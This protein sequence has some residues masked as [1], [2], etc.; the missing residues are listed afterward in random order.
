MLQDDREVA[1]SF[2][3]HELN[4]CETYLRHEF[5]SD[6]DAAGELSAPHEEPGKERG[7]S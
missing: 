3:G 2:E 6:L 4:R 7:Q 1:K 5:R